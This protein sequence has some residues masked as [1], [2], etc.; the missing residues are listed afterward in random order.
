[1]DFKD[2]YPHGKGRITLPDLS[3]YEGDFCMGFFHGYGTL[4]V[5]LSP[6]FYKGEWRIGEIH[7]KGWMTYGQNDWYEGEFQRSM[8]HGLGYRAYNDGT[9][10]E[11]NFSNNSINGEGN[12]LWNNNDYYIGEWSNG[13]QNGYGEYVWNIISHKCLAFANYNWYK[14]NWIQGMRCGAGIMSFG[15]E[16]GARLAG[17][18]EYNKKHGAGLV[19][20]G[21]GITVERNPLF[22]NDKPCTFIKPTAD[23]LPGLNSTIKSDI[24]T[25]SSFSNNPSQIYKDIS[26][27]IQSKDNLSTLNRTSLMDITKS[28]STIKTSQYLKLLQTNSGN[29]PPL[30]IPLH[31]IVEDLD[32]SFFIDNVLRNTVYPKSSDV[33]Q[34]E[35]QNLMSCKH[36]SGKHLG[37]SMSYIN[38]LSSNQDICANYVESKLMPTADLNPQELRNLIIMYLPQ[39]RDIYRKYASLG[40][41]DEKLSFEP[42]LVRFFLWQ[43]Y[44]DIGVTNKEGLSIVEVDEVLAKNPKSCLESTHNPWEPIFF[45]QFLQSIVN[46]CFLLFNVNMAIGFLTPDR[47]LY[48]IFKQFLDHTLL[49]QAGTIQGNSLTHLKHLVP[50]NCVY[51]LYKEIGEPHTV[52]TFLRNVCLEKRTKVPCYKIINNEKNRYT[53]QTGTNIVGL[54]NRLHFSKVTEENVII[55]PNSDQTQTNTLYTFSNLG[56]KCI[57]KAISKICPQIV[58]ENR[59]YTTRYQLSFLE[60]YEILLLLTYEKVEQARLEKC[61]E[62]TKLSAGLIDVRSTRDP[63]KMSQNDKSNIKLRKKQKIKA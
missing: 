42:V 11:G 56:R 33:S 12:M 10:Y 17:T 28:S 14:G 30:K 5:K 34:L 27:Q 63:S 23:A 61:K 41:I 3:T 43:L 44:R 46:I 29:N 8:R 36:A 13:Y 22:L 50:V 35:L 37:V 53:T 31:N 7:G 58:T 20:C 1:G 32:L 48:K 19:F 18:W 52:D 16:S 39:L 59:R 6:I 15:Y 9:R 2:G 38:Y 40:A 45:W 55:E 49:P 24:N 25:P 62:A 21:N 47:L 51:E 54:N 60:F 4:N 26:K 57:L